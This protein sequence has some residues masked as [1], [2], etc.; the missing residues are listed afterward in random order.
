[1]PDLGKSQKG[2]HHAVWLRVAFGGLTAKNVQAALYRNSMTSDRLTLIG[3]GAIKLLVQIKGLHRAWT[4]SKVSMAMLEQQ[5]ALLLDARKKIMKVVSRGL[6]DYPALTSALAHFVSEDDSLSIMRTQFHACELNNG[7][8]SIFS[9]GTEEGA[10]APLSKAQKGLGSAGLKP[11]GPL[12]WA[13]GVRCKAVRVLMFGRSKKKVLDPWKRDF[14][15]CPVWTNCL[16]RQLLARVDFNVP[17]QG[18]G[19]Q[20]KQT[21]RFVSSDVL[22]PLE[23]EGAVLVGAKILAIIWLRAS[24]GSLEPRDPLSERAT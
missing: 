21:L 18:F 10:E 4:S 16:E 22:G 1:M 11:S 24:K 13:H 14:G 2:E 17:L 19:T 6:P 23:L 3:A 9:C 7:I 20:A 15:M 5:H 8:R 12:F